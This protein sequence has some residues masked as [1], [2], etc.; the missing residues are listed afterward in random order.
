MKDPD[1][2]RI[3][4]L[5]KRLTQH[6]VFTFRPTLIRIRLHKT[7]WGDG[8]R[9]TEEHRDRQREGE[10]ER[11]GEIEIDRERETDR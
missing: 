3:S 7:S 8:R 10:R 4:L 9:E 5:S 11:E 2:A 6:L 1:F